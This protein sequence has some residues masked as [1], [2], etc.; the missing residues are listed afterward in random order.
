MMVDEL[1]IPQVAILFF[2]RVQAEIITN[3]RLQLSTGDMLRAAVDKKTPTGII[4]KVL[5]RTH[6]YVHT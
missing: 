4:A 2:L 6:K 1:G 3:F 5:L